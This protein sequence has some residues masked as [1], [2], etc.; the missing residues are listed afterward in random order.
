MND[1]L[2]NK[3]VFNQIKNLIYEIYNL[4][5]D[6]NGEYNM[7]KLVHFLSNEIK[8]MNHAKK[9]IENEIIQLQL[10]IT[11]YKKQIGIN[12]NNAIFYSNISINKLAHIHELTKCIELYEE[13]TI[14]NQILNDKISTEYKFLRLNTNNLLFPQNISLIE[15]NKLLEKEFI[16]MIER[17]NENELIRDKY[18]SYISKLTQYLKI[19][20]H[21]TYNES[22][23][24][25]ISIK[26][27]L[28]NKFNK[29][30]SIYYEVKTY[31]NYRN[32]II[33]NY[34]ISTNNCLNEISFDF[35]EAYDDD[36]INQIKLYYC[37][38]K[39]NEIIRDNIIITSYISLINQ[40]MNQYNLK[41]NEIYNKFNIN[42]SNIT[43]NIIP[44][45]I[46]ELNI[47]LMSLRMNFENIDIF[48]NLIIKRNKLLNSMKDFEKITVDP[49]R[50]FKSSLHLNKEEKFRKIAYPTLIKME[51]EILNKA[52]IFNNNIQLKIKKY[53]EEKNINKKLFIL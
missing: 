23:L 51:K 29:N 15:K 17:I 22:I 1:L 25:L 33:K 49:Q 27:K 38:L 12:D 20:I 53:L 39:K 11:N 9:I 44:I 13:Y 21:F 3:N 18:Y 37:D 34:N 26:D 6:L 7:Y 48:N 42:H 28:E 4:Y 31:I 32:N 14:K 40:T 36:S 47:M 46:N 10:Q 16:I 52:K 5:I 45:D 2:K 35:C 41:L 19:Q 8:L 43:Y 50:L 30:K 24:N